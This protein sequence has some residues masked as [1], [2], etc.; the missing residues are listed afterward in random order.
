MPSW[1]LYVG[2]EQYIKTVSVTAQGH[3]AS[4]ELPT[5]CFLLM[6]PF[7]THTLVPI[8]C[9]MRH[10]YYCKSVYDANLHTIIII[11]L[12]PMITGLHPQ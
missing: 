6:L 9:C 12:L 1:A 3:I 8:I 10:A 4:L 11:S 2:L 5:L 7:L